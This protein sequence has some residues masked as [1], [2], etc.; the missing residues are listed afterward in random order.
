MTTIRLD[1]PEVLQARSRSPCR[2]RNRRSKMTPPQYAQSL[3]VKAEK[4]LAWIRSGELR[5]IDAST[6][7]GRRPRYLIDLAD[8]LVFEQRRTVAADGRRRPPSR[9]RKKPDDV[10]EFF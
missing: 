7:P 8:I 1:E 6:R 3:G 5:A 10:I 9:R 2:G 4:V